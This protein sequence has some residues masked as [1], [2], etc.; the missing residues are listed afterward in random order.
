M[1]TEH[2]AGN[3][4]PFQRERSKPT[5]KRRGEK[6][7]KERKKDAPSLCRRSM[8]GPASEVFREEGKDMDR[9]IIEHLQ[10]WIIYVLR[11]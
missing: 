8:L 6:K 9:R 1:I 7:R 10:C 5:K 2:P 4:L 11:V 3:L